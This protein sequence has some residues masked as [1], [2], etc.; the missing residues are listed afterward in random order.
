MNEEIYC[1]Y[2][3]VLKDNRSINSMLAKRQFGMIEFKRPQH[4]IKKSP[5][6]ILDFIKKYSK[7]ITL[8]NIYENTDNL[9]K[10]V[11]FNLKNF[12]K[13]LMREFNLNFHKYEI[14][15][16]YKIIDK[17]IQRQWYGPTKFQRFYDKV[18]GILNKAATRFA[19]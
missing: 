14:E 3:R 18:F 7:N 15:K 5:K 12:D 17:K 2:Y 10:I 16:I 13:T 9:S 4:P 19:S 1:I 6:F 11:K 8:H